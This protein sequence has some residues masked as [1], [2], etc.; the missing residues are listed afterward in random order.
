MDATVK[1]FDEAIERL[2]GVVRILR[3]GPSA[4]AIDR[5]LAEPAR[6]TRVESLRDTEIVQRFRDDLVDGLIRVD[7]ANQLFRLIS[8]VIG[9]LPLI[10][11]GGG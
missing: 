6:Q 8:Q 10:G 5:V 2:D 4:D 9:M 3:S 7:T 1:V 11:V